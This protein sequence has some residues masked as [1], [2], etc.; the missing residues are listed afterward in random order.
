MKR[1][2]ALGLCLFLIFFEVLTVK[3][4]PGGFVS[5]DCGA[6]STY[7]D[8]TTGIVWVPDAKYIDGGQTANL[9]SSVTNS[10]PLQTLRYFPATQGKSCYTIGPANIRTRYLVR[11]TF[12]YGNYDGANT[13]PTFS[14][15]LDS[16]SWATVVIQNAT[17]PY[18]N[19]FVATAT[20]S[21]GFVVC[22]LPGTT[23]SSFISTLELRP[24][25]GPM[26][27]L[28]YINTAFLSSIVRIN[29]GAPSA[30]SVRFPDDPVDRIWASDQVSQLQDEASGTGRISTTQNVT[31]TSVNDIPPMKVMQT[32]A[33][34]N[35]GSLTYRL[36]L[37]SYFP[38]YCYATLYFAEIQNL[39]AG[40]I[41]EFNFSISINNTL[42]TGQPLDLVRDAG[43][44]TTFE[45]G[46]NNV[47]LPAILNFAL[48]RTSVS[49]LNPIVNAL[50]IYE[51]LPIVPGTFSGD[52]DAL[53]SFT[54]Q[55]PAVET[56][57]DPCLPVSWDFLTCST[58]SPPRV[59]DINLSGRN[60]TGSIPGAIGQMASL[61][62]LW[63]DNNQLTGSI[64]DLSQL[65]GLQTLHLQNNQLSGP[66]PSSLAKLDQLTEVFV[67]NNNLTGTV[68]SSLLNKGGLLLNASGNPY[69]CANSTCAGSSKSSVNIAAV[70]GGTV[71]GAVLLLVL[72]ACIVSFFLWRRYNNLKKIKKDPLEA[73]R[74]PFQPSDSLGLGYMNEDELPSPL[75]EGARLFHL[76]ELVVATDNFSKVIGSGGF[77]PVYYGKIVEDE[78]EIAVK[79]LSA[80]SS[81]GA[82][83]FFNE[84]NL[85]SRVHHRNL[86]TLIG[87]CSDIK[88]RML[89]YEYMHN[90]SL[91]DHLHGPRA[92]D[93]PIDWLARL[94]IAFDAAKGLEYLH[95]GCN[96]SI[97]HRDVKSSNILITENGAGKIADFGLSKLTT[98]GVSAVSTNVRGTVGYLDPEYYVSQQL[99]TKSDVFSFGVVLLEI[100]SG[101]EPIFSG[102]R[103]TLDTN[104]VN[105]ARSLLQKGD[106][107]S[108]VD[109]SLGFS[110]QIETLWKL[111]ELALR[112]VEP[113][114][115]YRPTMSEIVL[116]L[117]EIISME[118]VDSTVATGSD[119]DSFAGFSLARSRNH[120]PST[121]YIFDSSSI[122]PLHSGSL[123][124][125]Y[126]EPGLR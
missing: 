61:V 21:D 90:G 103:G 40:D 122:A 54:Q 52:V 42:F 59:T 34:G 71:G 114:G 81:Q 7:T 14:I 33:I 94:G 28:P 110:F 76:P 125:S 58:D 6:V 44:F 53:S 43:A 113:Y 5:I 36:N 56:P 119:D 57:G 62:N 111:A 64:P 25:I 2:Q 69:L 13:F 93:E 117:T 31:V 107:Q 101:R 26:Y 99:T 41:R 67:S 75:G 86:V 115:R 95:T 9:S 12:L 72:L 102:S 96:P 87:Y 126:N 118:T 84:V 123:E 83:E 80:S 39:G 104:L 120:S 91:R 88:E 20:S 50:E 30:D 8:P 100:I 66:F 108:I 24:L 49:T 60:L 15:S 32:A 97:I 23:G 105:W 45:P 10:V 51:I 73:S 55:L 77:G 3:A 27:L 46:F 11:A 109:P 29:F 16:S 98:E 92:E 63:L 124:D 112:S 22:L 70:V 78:Q 48:T 38:A 89:I 37:P 121:S 82:R 4:Q 68:P 65:A 19:E 18:F 35:Q 47:S 1:F 85:L 106:V 116:E 79:V 17:Y 74:Y